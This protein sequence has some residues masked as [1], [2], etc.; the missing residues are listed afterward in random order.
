MFKLIAAIAFII[1][2]SLVGSIL[3]IIFGGANAFWMSF[4]AG[5]GGLL[6]NIVA[7]ILNE[8]ALNMRQLQRLAV[9]LGISRFRRRR[10]I[11]VASA[12]LVVALLIV[13]SLFKFVDFRA[14]GNLSGFSKDVGFIT[15]IIDNSGSMGCKN[16]DG[17]KLNNG[18]CS[19]TGNYQVRL[20]KQWVREDFQSLD[21]VERLRIVE[22]G[23]LTKETESG[24]RCK[25]ETLIDTEDA[26]LDSLDAI[27][28]EIKANSSG[29]TNLS[30]A[31]IQAAEEVIASEGE[32][33]QVII[34][35][36]LEHNCGEPNVA[37]IVSELSELGWNQKTIKSAMDEVIVFSLSPASR[38]RL[39]ASRSGI[40]MAAIG[41]PIDPLVA[42]TKKQEIRALRQQGIKVIDL[43]NFNRL[44]RL[45][46][47]SNFNF[48]FWQIFSTSLLVFIVCQVALSLSR[49]GIRWEN[50]NLVIG[51]S[52]VGKEANRQQTSSTP[53]RKK[54]NL[55]KPNNTGRG[56]VKNRYR[57]S[58]QGAYPQGKEDISNHE[59]TKRQKLDE[60]EI[61][62][63]W[64]Y[65]KVKYLSLV[66]TWTDEKNNQ[67]FTL[68]SIEV[69][70]E[71]SEKYRL[72]KVGVRSE[73]GGPTSI[74]LSNSVDGSYLIS[75]EDVYRREDQTAPSI[76]DSNGVVEMSGAITRSRFN[77]PRNSQGKDKWNVCVV[78]VNDSSISIT[79]INKLDNYKT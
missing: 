72:F 78:K 66:I 64:N 30:G 25:V 36:D 33:Q 61:V 47:P 69:N 50:L 63:H 14:T 71:S 24:E 73:V 55:N 22:V 56:D 7:G 59:A 31:I 62:L 40:Q 68:D 45:S 11:A 23:G 75:V 77:C 8:E 21:A 38:E 2:Y 70:D 9:Q 42:L 39:N 65:P 1:V 27:L 58:A 46:I 49:G 6:G 79:E 76:S 18:Y 28:N 37:G 67:I 20:A 34:I 35:S 43:K 53:G 12:S 57:T 41:L 15:Y 29:A 16:K 48:N 52:G 10:W 4:I 44:E 51:F 54:K 32:N 5:I 19:E 74:I 3:S 13:G 17:F 26:D 60:I